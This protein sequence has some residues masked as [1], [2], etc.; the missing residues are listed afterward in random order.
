MIWA[1]ASS[2]YQKS[3]NSPYF[4]RRPAASAL[5]Q[6]FFILGCMPLSSAKRSWTRSSSAS[7]LPSV[8]VPLVRRAAHLTRAGSHP[9]LKLRKRKWRKTLSDIDP[10]WEGPGRGRLWRGF[11]SSPLKTHR[12]KCDL[13]SPPPL[14]P[15]EPSKTPITA[16][17]QPAAFSSRL[18]DAHQKALLSRLFLV[19]LLV[20]LAWL[21][22]VNG[23]G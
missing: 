13:T 5:A 11:V 17:G 7:I 4:S 21:C 6:K 1:Q 3:G 14:L 12:T 2:S 18:L 20:V 16:A 8:A 22:L 10:W 19:A 9:D 23:R 15:P